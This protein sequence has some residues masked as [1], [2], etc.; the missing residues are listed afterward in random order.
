MTDITLRLLLNVAG[1][2]QLRP[3]EYC[4]R[5]PMPECRLFLTALMG[6]PLGRARRH[7]FGRIKL[8]QVAPYIL[9]IYQIVEL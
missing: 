6:L 9:K 8:M 1:C 3:A 7:I 5:L 2:E 4:V